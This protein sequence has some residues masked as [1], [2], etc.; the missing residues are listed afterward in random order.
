MI[1]PFKINIQ[2][3]VLEDLKHRLHAARW[4]EDELVNDW[5][6]GV[7]SSWLRDICRY[8]ERSYDWRE[9][10]SLMNRVPHYKATIDGLQIHF[11]HRVSTYKNAKPLLMTH[12]WPGSFVEFLKVIEPLADPVAHGGKEEDAF[13]VVCPSLPGFGFSDK[14]TKT[15]CGVEQTA[16]LWGILMQ[17][18]GYS[19][20]LA[21]GGDWGSAVTSTLGWQD[22]NHCRGIHLTLAM[23]SHPR[24]EEPNT[25]EE[26]RAMEGVRHYR[27]WDSGYSKVQST[28]PQTIGF[29]LTDSPVGQA[30]WILEKFRFWTDCDAEPLNLFSKDEL[31][32]NVMIYWLNSTAASSARLY[33]ESF[34]SLKNNEIK[35]PTGVSVYPK[36][37]VPPVRKWMEQGQFKNIFYWS[38]KKKGGHF[39]AFEQP[40]IFIDDIRDWASSWLKFCSK[41][42][43]N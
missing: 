22:A 32:D 26:K 24:G 40:S 39:A 11:V 35:T 29:A 36:E 41:N 15:G 3:H 30:A 4:P 17:K 6:Q 7:P 21:Q 34:A 14:P 42:K 2:E 38:E 25:P 18:L 8:W 20:Y 13:H 10:E 1:T 27:K 31:L 23:N 33:W 16:H 12:G 5:S 19:W 28:R 37:I 43:P 9:R